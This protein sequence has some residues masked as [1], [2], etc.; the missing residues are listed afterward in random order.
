MDVALRTRFER[1]PE[2]EL[3]DPDGVTWAGGEVPGPRNIPIRF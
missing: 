1:I 2:F 3:P